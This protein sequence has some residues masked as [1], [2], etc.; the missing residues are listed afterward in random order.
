MPNVA[1]RNHTFLLVAI[2]ALPLSGC[3]SSGRTGYGSPP[4]SFDAG[5][6][7]V[8]RTTTIGHSFRLQ[9]TGNRVLKILRVEKSCGCLE[10]AI[11]P[12]E[13]GPWQAA[14]LAL[15]V[16][17]TPS[18]SERTV[19]CVVKTDDPINGSVSYSLAF[20]TFPR[21]QF[22]PTA[23]SLGTLRRTVSP[24]ADGDC[25]ADACLEV[26]RRPGEEVDSPGSSRNQTESVSRSAK[27]PPPMNQRPGSSGRAIHFVSGPAG[28]G[29][30]TDP[31]VNVSLL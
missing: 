21:V 1:T 2:S 20:K 4:H 24:G 29:S 17:V 27:G 31:P 30:P 8:E 10:A 15:S 18:Y 5:G 16:Q 19:G 14:R 26:F 9:N 22:R 23:L 3:S 25:A 7:V 28:T 11:T 6:I 12:Q 13:L